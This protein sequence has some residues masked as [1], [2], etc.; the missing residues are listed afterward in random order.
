[1]ADRCALSI[2]FSRWLII[3]ERTGKPRL[4]RHKLMPAEACDRL[5]SDQSAQ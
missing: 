5:H 1:V 3:D 2:E 4:K